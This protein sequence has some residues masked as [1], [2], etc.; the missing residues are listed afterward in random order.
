MDG[1][2]TIRHGHSRHPC[3]AATPSRY[4]G[5]RLRPL[6]RPLVGRAPASTCLR[7]H[8]CWAR[9]RTRHLVG[10]TDKVRR[11]LSERLWLEQ[12]PA[13]RIC[14]VT[15]DAL[16]L[17]SA[18]S[19]SQTHLAGQR[20]VVGEKSRSVA[21]GSDSDRSRTS[22]SKEGYCRARSARLDIFIGM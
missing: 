14:S 4:G 12:R 21:P 10:G 18:L 8:P 16:E 7:A 19:L 5:S 1:G 3:A 22:L 17:E 13:A 20:L 2:Y 11:G 6:T 15:E 9:R